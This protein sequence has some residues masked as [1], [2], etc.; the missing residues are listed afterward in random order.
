MKSKEKLTLKELNV[1]SFATALNKNKVK[2]GAESEVFT[3]CGE[4]CQPTK[5]PVECGTLRSNCCNP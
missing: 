4:F 3:E 2:G 5:Q 1:T